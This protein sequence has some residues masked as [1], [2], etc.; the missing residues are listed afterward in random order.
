G[1]S[2]Q[3][4]TE[5]IEVGTGAQVNTVTVSAVA[6]GQTYSVSDS[7]HFVVAA[8]LNGDVITIEGEVMSIEANVIVVADRMVV[9][10]P[11][12]P[13]LAVLEVGDVVRVEGTQD[14]KGVLTALVILIV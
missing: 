8:D 5:R 7:A 10:R 4:S 2:F 1:L 6:N 11:D 12:D 13:L 9:L 14:D 3:C